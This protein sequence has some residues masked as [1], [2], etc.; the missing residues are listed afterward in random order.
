[1][2]QATYESYTDTIE[3]N[4]TS[5]FYA[6]EGCGKPLIML[7]G[8]G[9]RHEDLATSIHQ[10]AQLGYKVYAIDSRGQGANAPLDEYHY[11]DMA[12]DVFQFIEKLGLEHPAVFGWSDGG[13]VALELELYNP[14]TVSMMAISGANISPDGIGKQAYRDMF[15][16]NNP[17]TPLVK[18]MMY[19]PNIAPERLE[20][21]QCPVLVMAGQYDLIQEDHTRLI[22]RSL[23][24]GELCIVEGH[25][26]GSHIYHNILLGNLLLPFLKK[27]NY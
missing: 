13:I 11:A 17:P 4:G 19:E 24:Q 27:H 6:V 22:A 8:N 3:V 25:D 18:M 15:I 10:M 14:G 5:L 16:Y 1:M 20:R 9:G 26:H 21:I 23:P 12:E 7:H 2:W